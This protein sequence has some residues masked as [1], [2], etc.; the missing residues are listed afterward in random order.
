MRSFFLFLS[1]AAAEPRLYVS[2]EDANQIAVVDA[3]RNQ[4]VATWNAGKRPRGLR[5]GPNHHLYVALSG[6]PKGCG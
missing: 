2:C 6:S 5:L 4:V 3:A 1:I